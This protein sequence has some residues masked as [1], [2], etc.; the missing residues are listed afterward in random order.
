MNYIWMDKKV[1]TNREIYINMSL[2]RF[3]VYNCQK[4]PCSFFK[5]PPTKSTTIHQITQILNN[6]RISPQIMNI[7]T[8]KCS[9]SK[10]LHIFAPDTRYIKT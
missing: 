4:F 9:S 2:T 6:V 8:N 3:V 5:F 10:T 1:K 7:L